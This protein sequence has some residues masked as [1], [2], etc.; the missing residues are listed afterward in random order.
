[1]GHGKE[2]PR[3][4]M[5]GMMYLMLT[6]MLA[7]NVSSEVLDAFRLVDEGIIRTTNNFHE[8]NQVIYEEFEQKYAENEQK[9][10]PWKDKADLVRERADSLFEYI[11]GI[12]MEIVMAAMGSDTSENP[13][14][15]NGKIIG[16]KLEGTDKYDDP[17][18]IMIGDNYNGEAYDLKEKLIEYREFLLDFV[19]P[20]DVG[21][22]SSIETSLDTSDPDPEETDNKEHTSWEIK[23]FYHIP[24]GG[25]MPILS[26]LQADVRNSETEIVQYLFKNIEAGSFKF[27]KLEA[28]VIPNTSYVIKGNPYKADIFLA[29][30]DTTAPP[31]VLIGEYDSTLLEDGSYEYTMRPGHDTLEVVNGKG[32]FSTLQNRVAEHSYKGIIKLRGPEGN[33]ITKTFHRSFRVAEPNL[34]V[35]PIKMNVFYVGVDNPV[36]ISISGVAGDKI[37]PDITNATIIKQRDGEYIV[38]PRRPGNSL[39]SVVAEMDGK[40]QSMGVV[41]FRVKGLPDPVAT[42]AGKNGGPINKNSFLAQRGVVAEMVNFDFDVEVTITQ[43]TVA[44]TDRSGYFKEEPTKGNLFTP[45][46]KGLIESTR[47]KGKVTIEDIKAVGPDGSVKNLSPIVFTLN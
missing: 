43:F 6:A 23:H 11:Q 36:K 9:V 30:V 47:R 32:K 42:V 19:E 15:E 12:K 38:R 28:T 46:Q 24:Y 21:T 44:T 5:I 45:A 37:F 13:A 40:R 17:T 22:I 7:L 39:I 3:Q 33:Y 1:M 29:A 14:I 20:E 2:T 4:K 25:C 31:I 26:K 16:Y 41:P 10:G 35:S 18:R 27:N 8:K 34:V